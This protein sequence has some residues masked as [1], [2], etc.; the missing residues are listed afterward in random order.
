M[1]A[2]RFYLFGGRGWSSRLIEWM[3]AGVFSHAATEWS[4]NEVLDARSDCI[5]GV[6]SGVHVRPL[7][8]EMGA[9]LVV[10]FS[11]AA[12]PEQIQTARRFLARQQGKPY[13]K[14]AIA[15]FAFGRN[16]REDDSWFCSEL[17]AAACEKAGLIK[18]LY[19]AYAKITPC[20][21]ADLISAAGATWEKIQ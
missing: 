9:D 3:S 18:P 13:D 11:L 7:R 1:K 19:S 6:P 14:P 4:E 21:F 16:W 2:L 15:G 17:C 5:G 20:A 12:T 10:R 8:A